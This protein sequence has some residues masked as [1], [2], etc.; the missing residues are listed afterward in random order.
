[1]P[2]S[3]QGGSY[4]PEGA[5]A[6]W[7]GPEENFGLGANTSGTYDFETRFYI[8][9]GDPK[10]ATVTG[11]IIPA[12]GTGA[13]SS[14]SLVLN[15]QQTNLVVSGNPLTTPVPFTLSVANGLVAGSNALDFI[16][17][18][19]GTAAVGIQV[20]LNGICTN[21]LPPG[22]PV[23]TNQPGDQIVPYGSTVTLPVVVLGQPPLSYQWYSN[24]IAIDDT[25]TPSAAT[26]ALTFVGTNFSSSEVVGTNFTADYQVVVSND[27]GSV[28]SAVGVV[29]I[30]IPQMAAI[31][32]GVPIWTP[33]G[34]ETN[35][36]VIFSKNVD[37]ATAAVAANY[38]LDNSGSVLSAALVAPNEVVLDTS[39]LN[40]AT[41]Y[42]L[43][44]QNVNDFLGVPMQDGAVQVGTYPAAA[45]RLRA[46]SGITTDSGGV[47]AWNDLSGNGNNLSQ[48]NGPPFEPQLVTNA[49]HGPTV[50][51]IGTNQTFMSAQSSP[52]LAITGDLSIIAV[53]NYST[54]AG[55]I[56][57]M[58]VSKTSG[59]VPATF[60]YYST[61]SATRFFRGNGTLYG[62]INSTNVPATGNPHLL[63][64][65]MQGSN[66]VERLDG[67]V[68]GTGPIFAPRV[69]SGDPLYIGGRAD[70]GDFLTGGLSELLV[71]GSA[72]SSYDISML[73]GYL[74]T[75]YNLP[76]GA[77]SY[78]VITQQPV[79]FT[80]INQNTILTVAAAVSGVPA[81][82]DQWYNTNNVPVAGQTN[83]TLVISNVAANEGFYLVATNVYGTATS[84]V[85]TV[86]LNTGL[87]VSLGPPA[88]T[89]Y[90]GQRVTL[91]A[92]AS[93]TAPFDYQ[94]Y[95]GG[96]LIPGATNA[97]Y[98]VVASGTASFS[99]T[100]T[101][102]YNGYSSTNAGPVALSSVAAP[103]TLY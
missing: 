84:E 28:T 63:D 101:N 103:T 51:F 78:P 53:V 72:L 70:F 3:G 73:E 20:Q 87:M 61:A 23:I 52:S 64:V 17:P 58:I 54:L 1:A 39:A 90:T 83:A 49:L 71:V 27:S 93:G 62:E 2:L 33:T 94:W 11:S 29:T 80:N 15:G 97:T 95:Q 37:P 12:Y 13:G 91:D 46:D 4:A 5:S 66:V 26:R 32:A 55:G 8:Q 48:L 85:V 7:I 75:A 65:V 88:V 40:P 98:T 42:T 59:G 30:A 6:G 89:L 77:N 68:N 79:A 81:V 57:G 25:A 60:D 36:I 47:N 14:I 67:V 50:E 43:T 76:L 56:N 45:L 41:T 69:D 16:L 82:S 24:G 38:S 18:G 86:T 92:V 100:V 9:Q 102:G 99:C 22:L 10:S 19:N 44:V 74:A 96:L 34:D 21:A 31:S 35:I